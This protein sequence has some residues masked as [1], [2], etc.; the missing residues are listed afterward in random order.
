MKEYNIGDVVWWA[1][2]GTRQV[3]HDCPI[4]NKKGVVTVILGNGEYV[5]TQCD[6]CGKG[7]PYPSGFVYE[8]EWTTEVKQIVIEGKNVTE[9]SEGRQVDY[10]NNGCILH[11]GIMAASKEEAEKLRDEICAKH[12]LEEMERLQRGKE[13]NVK[14]YSWHV[15]YHQRQLKN[16]QR[17][18]DYHFKKIT[19]MKAKAKD[20]HA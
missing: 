5:E 8:W 14:S 2:G 19:Y 11:N 12:H 4:C 16:A 3:K 18:V 7:Q 15:G 10:R 13:N 1:T 20:T 17:D 9:S 6:F